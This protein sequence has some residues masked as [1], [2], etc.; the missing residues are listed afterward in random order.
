MIRRAK[1]PVAA[2]IFF[3]L[4]VLSPILAQETPLD[5]P[6]PIAPLP[7]AIDQET[8]FLGIGESS[9]A[10]PLAP[11]PAM[12]TGYT[13]NYNTVSIIEYIRFAS[14][15]CNVNFLFNE[16]DLQF[17]VTVVSDEP[18]T[19]ENVMSMLIQTLRIHGLF[20]LEQDNNLVIHKSSDV[21]QMARLVTES[22]QS[23]KSSIVTRIFRI[24]NAKTESVAAIIRPLISGGAII[25]V[26][27][28]TRQLILTDISTN[29]D[30]VAMLIEN[31]D[32][33]HTL[34]EIGTFDTKNNSPEYL[35][36]L[37]S[38]IM[39]PIA[40]GNPFTLVPQNLSNQ[41]FIVSTPELTSR[42]I[43]VLRELDSPA[44]RGSSSGQ[45]QMENIFVYKPT[46]R[47]GD[48]I[49]RG[50]HMIAG[51]L[52]QSGFSESPLIET[53]DSARW[54]PDTNSLIFLGN[55]ETLDK[56]K[57]LLSTLDSPDGQDALQSA[58]ASK[59]G[60]ESFFLHTVKG[61][62]N[63]I[64]SS[65][66]GFA[67]HLDQSNAADE[68]LV[69][70]IQTMRYIPESGAFLFTGPK[71]TLK[72][73]QELLGKFDAGQGSSLPASSQFFIYK[74]TQLK[75]D[76]LMH[77]IK[78]V[79]ANLKA[80]HLADPAFLQTIESMK[81]V[82][83]TNS[84]LFTGDSASI[85]KL[86]ALLTTLDIPSSG[87]TEEQKFLLFPLQSAKKTDVEHYLKQVASHLNKKDD[88][89]IIDAI[90]SIQ[91]IE[92]SR[93]FMF[94]GS[95]RALTD[96]QDLLTRFDT[97]ASLSNFML[98]QPRYADRK[99]TDTYLEQVASNL[100][101][102]GG[103][104]PLLA[105]IQSKKW[106]D[107]SGSFMFTGDDATLTKLKDLLANFDS[108]SDLGLKSKKPAYFLYRL[109]NVSGSV[110][111]E[112]LDSLEKKFKSTGVNNPKLFEVIDHIRFIKET[113]SLL[114]TGDPDAVEEIKEII[115]QYDVPRQ[116]TGVIG[117][118][119]FLLYNLK[120]AS[121]SHLLS[122][123]HS[124]AHDL[125][126]SGATDPELLA[127]ISSAKYVKET[128]SILFIGTQD[129]LDKVQVLVQKFD[130][131]TLGAPSSQPQIVTAGNFYV[132]KPQS[133]PGPELEKMVQNFGDNLR[134]SGLQDPELF[135]AIASMRWVEMSQSLIFTGSSKSLDQIKTLIASF[136]VASNYGGTVDSSIQ[137]IDNTSFLV[138]K[139]Q[140]HRGEE[141]QG[142]LRQIA[143]D[144]VGN[145]APINQNLLNAIN[146]I[147]WIEVTNSLLC[148]GD[149]DT[150]TR[151]KELIKNLDVPL[152]QVFV[153]MLIVQTT[154]ANT[155]DF[156]LEW[157]S[158][159]KYNDKL[160]GSMGNFFDA[161]DTFATNLGDVTASNTPVPSS[162]PFNSGYTLGVIG[163]VIKHSGN[164]FLTLGS[165]LTALQA[166]EETTVVMT[167]KMLMQDGKT[168]TLFVGNNYPFVGSFVSQE[169]SNTVQ[170]SN[171][172]YRNVGFS[173][174]M[175][176]VLG[177]S[178]IV[179][180]DININSSA[181][182]GSTTS[183]TDFT[184]SSAEGIQ[185]SLAT[186]QTTVH[187]PDNTFL[188]LTGMVDNSNAKTK[189]GIP[190]LGSLPLIGAAFSEYN[191]VDSYDNIVVFLRP[192]ILNSMDDIRRITLEQEEYFRDQ[193]PTPY[194]QKNFDEGMEL[195]KTVDDD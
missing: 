127:A 163:E 11:Q 23:G 55:G 33:P 165:L 123:L 43:E 96:V 117:Q 111:E 186:I 48:D 118:T 41:V 179:T 95:E 122:S 1:L 149:Q 137:S 141:I 30:K 22:G 100:N 121:G 78:D 4:L 193:A 188:I 39:H 73:I 14:K 106:I 114:L 91:W 103:D 191:D 71:S 143:K 162:I 173:L 44:K 54:I 58:L 99:Q 24:K 60:T 192:H 27:E 52:Q 45:F 166:E 110:V 28:E 57:E 140:F 116:M 46:Q 109:Q 189:Q 154:L 176:P 84:L 119:T 36:T 89:E 125:K 65:L 42:A 97:Q 161:S 7:A 8:A 185:T 183:T 80:G 2:L 98:Y 108:P 148:T 49:L 155:L 131:S 101:Q 72:R 160:S 10:T 83:S 130:V 158:K 34:L 113:N 124:L 128:N 82:K 9:P 147:Q 180:L 171:L 93:S 139:L 32:S 133:V 138:Y 64:E 26:S 102:K 53:I 20:L 129:A 94:H 29:V 70:V 37:A 182:V 77:S 86:Q 157:G 76:Q 195:I 170:T 25:E 5:H 105:A 61:D 194:L 21:K 144:L 126:K 67:S 50:L 169:G 181:V 184:T 6:E 175:T 17:T 79:T 3:Y 19:P 112:D 75:G 177:N 31:L 132:Y 35:I 136:D 15:I 174:T 152:K 81:W 172:E 153:E 190:C 13:I 87:Q 68:G 66:K 187:V 62:P 151:L 146:S 12:P 104:A 142:A 145:N 159:Y 90:R 59:K 167:P 56:L 63:Q 47:S 69:G 168:S 40:Q 156:G 178:N 38:Q 51:S 88:A 164:T 85:A 120:I 74:P 134:L 135:Q 16:E 107:E 18:I 150:L 92:P 115:A